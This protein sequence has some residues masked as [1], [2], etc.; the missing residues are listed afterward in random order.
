MSTCPLWNSA[1]I[2]FANTPAGVELASIRI[3]LT[4]QCNKHFNSGLVPPIGTSYGECCEFRQDLQIEK[5][6]QIQ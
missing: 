2:F 6:H 3:R 4:L 5:R 1:S